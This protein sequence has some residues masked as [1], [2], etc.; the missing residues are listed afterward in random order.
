VTVT[1]PDARGVVPERVQTTASLN[2]VQEVEPEV[3]SQYAPPFVQ[4]T[5]AESEPTLEQQKSELSG[6]AP[7]NPNPVPLK[8]KSQKTVTPPGYGDKD[9]TSG[10]PSA[11]E[12]KR[13]AQEQPPVDTKEELPQTVEAS[14]P[15]LPVHDDDDVQEE[16]RNKAT[17]VEQGVTQEQLRVEPMGAASQKSRNLEAFK[18]SEAAMEE[19]A[20]GQ[21]PLLQAAPIVP[22]PLGQAA[23]P[24]AAL[25]QATLAEAPPKQ[26]ARELPASANVA[27]AAPKVVP[28]GLGAA[29]P[30]S[31]ISGSLAEHPAQVQAPLDPTSNVAKSS[32]AMSSAETSSAEAPIGTELSALEG[33]RSGAEPWNP[34]AAVAKE[35]TGSA[36]P[37]P[38]SVAASKIAEPLESKGATRTVP[39]G[40][41]SLEA[42]ETAAQD[43]S[44]NS[45]GLAPPA[46]FE[47]TI[48]SKLPEKQRESGIK[49][50]FF[51]CDE[52]VISVSFLEKVNLF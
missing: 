40:S 26:A 7:K 31:L 51:R 35:V 2:E 42:S 21:A 23:S 4:S 44:S 18:T 52:I 36:S 8:E 10:P 29:V 37:E 30:G 41:G 1:D 43:T 50:F 34:E 15:N 32:A 47:T 3:V 6:A 48:A 27:F 24:Q 17:L 14:Q 19:A 39:S 45:R 16:L 11:P 25:K 22:V 12:V 38:D 5:L 33:E 20:K 46:Q 9:E 49:L 13:K 28:M